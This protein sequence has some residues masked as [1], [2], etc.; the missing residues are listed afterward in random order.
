MG[1][2]VVSWPSGETANLRAYEAGYQAAHTGYQDL[3]QRYV[4]ELEKRRIKLGSTVG[5]LAAL[6]VGEVIGSRIHE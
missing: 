6:G 2:R 1:C 5:V 3:S 4:E